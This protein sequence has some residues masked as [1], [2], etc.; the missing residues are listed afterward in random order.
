M[1]CKMCCPFCCTITM[2]PYE[3]GFQFL[4]EI[5]EL[6]LEQGQAPGCFQ[7]LHTVGM[8]IIIKGNVDYKGQISFSLL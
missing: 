7:A 8:N 4:Q 1:V 6:K 3:F 2:F 5:S